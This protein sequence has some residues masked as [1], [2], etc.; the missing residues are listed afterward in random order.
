ML[1]KS[2]NIHDFAGVDHYISLFATATQQVQSTTMAIAIVSHSIYCFRRAL[3]NVKLCFSTKNLDGERKN[4]SL[5][6]ET[7]FLFWKINMPKNAM[8]RLT[9]P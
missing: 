6:F 8:I 7:H 9:T 4:D 3:Q 2:Y 5:K 1:F